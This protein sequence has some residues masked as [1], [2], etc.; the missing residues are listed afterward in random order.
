MH[1]DKVSSPSLRRSIESPMSSKKFSS[2]AGFTLVELM[3]T[4]AIVGILIAVALPSYSE[5]IRRS[6]RLEARTTLF[7]AAAWMERNFSVGNSYLAAGIFPEIPE[8]LNR[9]PKTGLPKY[10][11]SVMAGATRSTYSL[12][13]EP[14]ATPLDKCG[15]FMLDETGVRSLGENAKAAV[16][17][18]WR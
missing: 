7:E 12:Q 5:Y 13:A 16:A 18:C 6:D 3:I 14:Q 9:S 4:V 11:I 10:V 8:G 15:T 2:S 17:E 1:I